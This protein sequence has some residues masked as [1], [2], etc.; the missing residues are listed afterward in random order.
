MSSLEIPLPSQA[1]MF[2]QLPTELILDHVCPYFSDNGLL[3]YFR[4]MNKLFDHV[5][6]SIHVKTLLVKNHFEYQL[7][8]PVSS[9]LELIRKLQK[10]EYILTS[11]VHTINFLQCPLKDYLEQV[12]EACPNLKK[13]E[14]TLFQQYSHSNMQVITKYCKN[15]EV[16]DC[17]HARDLPENSNRFAIFNL[18]QCEN[19][20]FIKNLHH[21]STVNIECWNDTVPLQEWFSHINNE[22]EF[23]ISHNASIEKHSL[24]LLPESTHVAFTRYPEQVMIQTIFQY[25]AFF[26]DSLI[27]SSDSLNI[28]PNI[29]FSI[30]VEHRIRYLKIEILRQC[31]TI[32]L[33]GSCQDVQDVLNH[34]YFLEH[35]PHLEELDLSALFIDWFEPR[36]HQEHGAKPITHSKKRS[37]P[38]LESPCMKQNLELAIQYRIKLVEL[39]TRCESL[40][41][42]RIGIPITVLIT[43]GPLL[44]DSLCHENLDR[45]IKL[46][47]IPRNEFYAVVNSESRCPHVLLKRRRK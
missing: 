8:P 22:L 11:S 38:I 9:F 40:Q 33:S 46:D 39:M 3:L 41:R 7:I 2:S 14:P 13:V 44:K 12:C 27:H 43:C 26:N 20:A 35:A 45:M 42:V 25:S 28:H 4:S 36:P 29:F 21:V 47:W 5:I 6:T 16:I 10:L 23:R 18:H 37:T 30:H 19:I 1:N 17:Y 32:I 31:K 15:Y 34:D 24:P